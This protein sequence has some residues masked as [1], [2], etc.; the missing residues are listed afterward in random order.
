LYQA[1]FNM[2]WSAASQFPAVREEIFLPIE[3]DQFDLFRPTC[4]ETGKVIPVNLFDEPFHE[5]YH[6]RTLDEINETAVSFKMAIV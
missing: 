1:M 5:D 4:I 6:P 3:G 2:N